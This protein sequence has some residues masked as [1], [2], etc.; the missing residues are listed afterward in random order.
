MAVVDTQ[1]AV[2]G[3]GIVGLACAAALASGGLPTIVLE[4]HKK[5]GTET[6]SRNSQVIH[7][8][9]YYEPGSLKAELCVRG[10]AQLYAYCERRGVE[11]KRVGKLVVADAGEVP[12]LEALAER[13]TRNG[14]L[15]SLVGAA[16]VAELEPNVRASAALESP[17]TGIVDTHGFVD[18]VAADLAS[19]G[20]LLACGREVV[21]AERDGAAWLLRCEGAAGEEQ[22]RAPVVINAAGLVAD[23]VAALF[24]IDVDARGY[25]QRWVKGNY[26]RI[27]GAPLVSRLVYPMPPKD[28]EGLGIHAT[29]ELDGSVRLGPDTEPVAAIE[30]SV[31]EGR[32]A[33]FHRAASRYLPSLRPEQLEP[34]MAGIRPKLARGSDFVIER[35]AAS[36]VWNLVGI[37]SPGLTAALAIAERVARAILEG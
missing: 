12:L 11:H 35:D 5:P 21:G 6:T 31:D 13:A 18:A 19:S 33:A 16:R 26:F 25:R 27:K 7:G 32:R 14:A 28:G 30:Y 4:R 22:V 2:V 23:A 37:E 20:G 10:A 29:V 1:V 15:V 3:G 24:G 17:A 8:G 36:G 34:D 9:L